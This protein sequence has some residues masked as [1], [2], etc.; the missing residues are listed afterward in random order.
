MARTKV[1]ARPTPAQQIL[2]AEFI[3]FPAEDRAWIELQDAVIAATGKPIEDLNCGDLNLLRSALSAPE[4]AAIRDYRRRRRLETSA[5]FDGIQGSKSW[6]DRRC[7]W[8]YE[9]LADFLDYM[10]A[11]TVWLQWIFSEETQNLYMDILEEFERKMFEKLNLHPGLVHELTPKYE[12]LINKLTV[13]VPQ[14]LP[15]RGGLDLLEEFYRQLNAREKKLKR[16]RAQ[17]TTE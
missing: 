13:N 7:D 1:T 14:L 12:E 5:E 6:R 2:S 9:E 17:A 10:R 4:L 8:T 15:C 3:E 16:S 11:V